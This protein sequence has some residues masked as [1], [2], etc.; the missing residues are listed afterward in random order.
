MYDTPTF[1]TE[2]LNL[3]TYVCTTVL[4]DHKVKV[5]AYTALLSLTRSVSMIYFNFKAMPTS[6]LTTAAIIKL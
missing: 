2:M 5:M 3:S 1:T 6:E 4:K